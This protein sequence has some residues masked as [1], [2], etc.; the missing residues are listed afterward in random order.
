VYLTEIQVLVGLFILG[1]DAREAGGDHVVGIEAV[2]VL[3]HRIVPCGYF[4]NPVGVVL[5]Q[6][7]FI[8]E[9]V[10][11]Q[12]CAVAPT[13]HDV[14]VPVGKARG[15]Q[16]LQLRRTPSDVENGHSVRYLCRR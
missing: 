7:N 12:S 2:K 10:D 8:P 1:V 5:S 13:R 16:F 11:H 6:V 15:E 9:F 3:F 14:M 4:W